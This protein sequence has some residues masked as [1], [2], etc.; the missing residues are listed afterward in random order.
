MC[1]VNTDGVPAVEYLVGDITRNDV[2]ASVIALTIDA[3]L[4]SGIA[5]DAIGVISP[6]RSQVKTIQDKIR[7]TN[8]RVR[9]ILQVSFFSS[10]TCI[11]SSIHSRLCESIPESHT[12]FIYSI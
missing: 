12:L 7:E 6:W 1:F 9:V 4:A 5:H 8:R 10:D 2:E 11:M 3:L